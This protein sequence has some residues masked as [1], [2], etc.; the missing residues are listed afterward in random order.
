MKLE[1]ET[2]GI[3]WTFW[4]ILG[5]MLRLN[6]PL[7]CICSYLMQSLPSVQYLPDMFFHLYTKTGATL[8]CFALYAIL[9]SNQ[10]I[11]PNHPNTWNPMKTQTKKK[12]EPPPLAYFSD[13]WLKGGGIS[14]FYKFSRIREQSLEFLPW[15][16]R[17]WGNS[18]TFWCHGIQRDHT[19]EIY[20]NPRK[21]FCFRVSSVANTELPTCVRQTMEG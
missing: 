4:F 21:S 15:R 18:H 14:F 16:K 13:S 7:K 9:L 10:F 6:I 17:L 5:L 2:G 20:S 19:N 3:S 1:S 12:F 11:P 8:C